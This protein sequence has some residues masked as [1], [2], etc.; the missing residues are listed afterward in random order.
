MPSI[1]AATA[2]LGVGGETSA[3]GRAG[4]MDVLLVVCE[5]ISL[6]GLI[7]EPGRGAAAWGKS[8][9]LHREP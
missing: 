3:D 1:S 2:S 9:V 5:E 6:D 8:R 7:F 4:V